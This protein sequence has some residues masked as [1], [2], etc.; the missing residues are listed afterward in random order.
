VLTLSDVRAA[1]DPI[2]NLRRI[3]LRK[4]GVGEHHLAPLDGLRALALLWVIF[5]HAGWYAWFVLPPTRYAM[6]LYAPWMLPFWRGD[7]AVEVFFVM[8]GFLIG[9]LITDER[10]RTGSVNVVRFYV[11]RLFRLWPA[12]VVATICEWWIVGGPADHEI[13]P[14]IFY[15]NNFMPILSVRMGWTWS[16]AIEEQFY[17]TVPWL[18]GLLRRLEAR[19]AASRFGWIDP[20]LAGLGALAVLLMGVIAAVVVATDMHP[21]DTEVT[22][23]R[24]EDLWAHAYDVLYSKPWMRAGPLLAGLGCA[25]LWRTEGFVERLGRSGRT[26]TVL[27]VLAFL[28]GFACMHW[29]LFEGAPRAVEVLYIASYRTVFGLVVAYGMM[30]VLSPHPV[31]AALGRFLSA[32]IFYP[33]AQL[34]YCAYLLNPVVAVRAHQWLVQIPGVVENSFPY[35]AAVDL[36]GTFAAALLL[37]VLVER[38]FM[39]LRRVLAPNR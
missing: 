2:A 6:L 36:V 17:L 18:L 30:L 10:T 39:E 25:R 8:S 3:F 11:R 13:W 33:M 38:P 19:R 34:A 21:A 14:N 26:G 28:V 15:V 24:A 4:A 23:N 5:C 32:P 22:F 31:G 20:T 35:F 7:F 9:G 16:L 29:P 27:L 37:S 1:F 12:L